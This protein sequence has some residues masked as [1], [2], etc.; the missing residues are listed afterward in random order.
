M[1]ASVVILKLFPVIFVGL[2]TGITSRLYSLAKSR[3]R[4]SCAGQPKI[5]PNPYSLRTKLATKIGSFLPSINGWF[6]NKPV[7][8]PLLTLSGL[9]F[10]QS[11]WRGWPRASRRKR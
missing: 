6:A 7:S 10:L 2:T 8:K 1:K 5:A 3:S 4:W 11:Y 9:I